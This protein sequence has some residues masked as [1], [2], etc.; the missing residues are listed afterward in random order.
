[1]IP[2]RPVRVRYGLSPMG[3]ALE[4]ALGEL[5]RWARCWLAEDD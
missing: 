5:Q 2:G 3:H 4:P 1:V